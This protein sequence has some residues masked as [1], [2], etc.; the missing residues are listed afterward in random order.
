MKNLV[1]AQHRFDYLLSIGFSLRIEERDVLFGATLTLQVDRQQ[2]RAAGHE[3]PEDA[4]AV[5]RVTHRGR[6]LR[7]DSRVDPRIPSAFA[8]AEGCICF[9]DN[10]HDGRESLKEVQNLFQ[11]RFAGTDPSFPEILERDYIQAAIVREAF[12][13]KRF[14]CADRSGY[15]NAHW[16]LFRNPGF[17]SFRNRPHELLG[18]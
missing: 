15:E 11:I 16:G 10:H 1:L 14:A 7:E 3:Y 2:V 12:R 5:F 18:L 8:R 6:K 17:Y 13:Q 4:A 9:V